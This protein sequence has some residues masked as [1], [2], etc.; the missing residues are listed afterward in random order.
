M[1]VLHKI[2]RYKPAN[3]SLFWKGLGNYCETLYEALEKECSIFL[4]FE[5]EEVINNITG[6]SCTF[7][8]LREENLMHL[9]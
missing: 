2:T 3:N 7:L 4:L 6:G 8:E 1:Y 9:S 5:K